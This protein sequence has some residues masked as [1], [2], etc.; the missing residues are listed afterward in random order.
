[1]YRDLWRLDTKTNAWE[2]L[3]LQGRSPSPRSGH[4][5][6]VWRNFLV[7][8]GG[9][10]EAAREVKWYSDLYVLSLQD[11]KWRKIEIPITAVQPAAR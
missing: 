3:E 2:S 7:L 1:V 11:L 4:R 5:M 10:Y 8:F 9:F 6:A